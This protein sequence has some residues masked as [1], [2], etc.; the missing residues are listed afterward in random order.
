M[1][2]INLG[3]AIGLTAAGISGSLRGAM[4]PLTRCRALVLSILLFAGCAVLAQPNSDAL[5]VVRDAHPWEFVDS[6][7]QQSAIFGNE[8]G[9]L[10]GWVYPLKFFKNFHLTFHAAGQV[11]LPA[12]SLARTVVTR[13]ESTTIVYAG[14]D[15][16]V[17]E[18]LFAPVSAPGAVILIDVVASNPVEVEAELETDVQLAWPA[19]V[20]G[21]Y[22]HY[23]DDTRRFE[24]GADGRK[25][26]GL[27][28]SPTASVLS[29]PYDSNYS[30]SNRIALS[31][32]PAAKGHQQYAIGWALSTETP[33]AALE[34]Y[35]RL[36]GQTPMLLQESAKYYNDYLARTVNISVPDSELQS[37]YDWSRVA[38]VQGMVNSP[39]TG[40]GMVAGYRTS[41]NYRAGFNWFF[42]RDSLWT[43]LGL[44]KEGD[45]EN[46][47]TVLNFLASFQ[48][49][50]GKIAHEI[51]HLAKET[52]W[53]KAYP[54]AFA[55]A[56]A[57]PLFLIVAREYVRTTG[58]QAWLKENW[59]HVS[60]AYNFL[61]NTRANGTW[62][63]NAGVGHGWIEG[64]PLR[65][66]VETEFYQA[67][68]A[69]E[70]M[71]AMSELSRSAG[72]ADAAQKA[73]QQADSLEKK[74]DV[75][76][77]S[78]KSNAID[79]GIDSAGK[80]VEHP[81]VL[82]AAPMWWS[83]LSEEKAEKTLNV[84]GSPEI[85]ADWGSRIIS[86]KDEYYDP[87]GYHFG[88]IWP[89][90]TGWASVADYRWHRPLE[91]YAQLRDNVLLA[92][93][94]QPGHVTEVLSGSY[95]VP[96]STGTSH[97]IWS[98]GMVLSSVLRGMFGIEAS[99]D[100]TLTL[101]PH[102]PATW[103]S[104]S[105]ENLRAGGANVAISYER[106]GGELTFT[107]QNRGSS[108]VHITL[109]PAVSLNAT[110][111]GATLDGQHTKIEAQ[112]SSQ[113]Q[114]LAVHADVAAGAK[115]TVVYHVKNDFGLEYASQLPA[116]GYASEGLRFTK[117]QWSGM[118][119][120]FE[121]SGRSG[122]SYLVKVG[123]DAEIQS[124]DNADPVN[125]RGE[126][127]LRIS[128][129]VGS[130][131]YESKTVTVHLRKR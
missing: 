2:R 43:S 121:V 98:S 76:F 13:P 92:H 128:F 10:E 8:S 1:A 82:V 123:G 23:H 125:E 26:F 38:V 103:N 113:D 126:R 45:F 81:T 89:L 14:D 19:A 122:H 27:F 91:G 68:L 57:T 96:L 107:L 6:V 4:H 44:L 16:S 111:A 30:S 116:R 5:Q 115:R 74:L 119:A 51:A 90:F 93:S 24:V 17:R 104:A 63:R 3:D 29:V 33:Q 60:R 71:R 110:V 100:G 88:S 52:D 67:G 9:V 131:G 117:E 25:L 70:A 31:L 84:L 114:H 75:D 95:F 58:D 55:S 46:V 64:G 48:R 39:G 42:G 118:T 78:T 73:Q 12:E 99:A 112:T 22:F 11:V 69:V 130:E 87:S 37:A 80:V 54:Y 59:D 49:E 124:V 41:F 18:T 32:G 127:F 86:D 61:L 94:G 102:F 47:K 21:T 120:S 97:Q 20:G 50:D 15:F 108:A 101:A 62:P 65:P 34:T 72:Q 79:L 106:H 35:N 105:I 56:D 66:L 7:G 36:F 77:W 129:A 40:F 83:H 53:F 109:S 85:A 28:G